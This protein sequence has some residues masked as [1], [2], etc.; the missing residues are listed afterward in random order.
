MIEGTSTESPSRNGRTSTSALRVSISPPTTTSTSGTPS[1]ASPNT[2]PIAS[3]IH[4]PTTPPCQPSQR[5]VARK[6]PVATSPRPI[7]SGWWW[8]RA[9]RVRF[10][11]RAGVFGRTLRRRFLCAMGASSG[12]GLPFLLDPPERRAEHPEVGRALVRQQLGAVRAAEGAVEHEHLPQAV[13]LRGPGEVAEVEQR[14]EAALADDL[15]HALVVVGRRGIEAVRPV[16]GVRVAVVG[17]RDERD[18]AAG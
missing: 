2:S 8:P 10:F 4:S 1:A 13:G 9:F 3:A 18:P 7:S 15:D 14:V 16:R 5:S 11:T 12:D 6:I 17:A